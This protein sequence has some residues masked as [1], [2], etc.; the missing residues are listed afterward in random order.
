MK[1]ICLIIVAILMLS[2][3]VLPVSADN[4]FEPFADLVVKSGSAYLNSSGKGIFKLTTKQD[5]AEIKVTS[6]SL[7]KKDGRNSSFVKSLDTP[8]NVAKNRSLYSATVD[9]SSHLTSGQTNYIVATFNI[10]GY[11]KVY[12]SP[13][14]TI[15]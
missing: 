13:T 7:Y 9:Y 3:Q 2:I 12:T 1:K 5:A 11:E 8:T 15:K 4:R 10:D 14:V 6:C